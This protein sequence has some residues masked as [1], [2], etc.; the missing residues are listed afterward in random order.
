M[1]AE[2]NPAGIKAFMSEKG[3]VKNSVRLPV[4]PVSKGLHEKIKLYLSI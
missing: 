3:L 1:F 4:V 2:N